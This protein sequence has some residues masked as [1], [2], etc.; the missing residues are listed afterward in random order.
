MCVFQGEIW[1]SLTAAHMELDGG[2]SHGFLILIRGRSS[3]TAEI[4]EAEWKHCCH[5]E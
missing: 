3:L 2:G 4:C 5:H 1:L